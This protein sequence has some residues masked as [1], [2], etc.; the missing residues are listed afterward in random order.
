MKPTVIPYIAVLLAASAYAA[1]APPISSI[2]ISMLEEGFNP[3]PLDKWLTEQLGEE[4]K[5]TS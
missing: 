2:D 5:I 3:Q 1:D 4:W